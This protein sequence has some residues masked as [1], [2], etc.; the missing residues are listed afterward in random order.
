VPRELVV[1][2]QQGDADAFEALVTA[3]ADRWYATATLILHDRSRAEDAVQETM[4]R[5]WRDLPRLRDPERFDAWSRR[6]LVHACLDLAR[7]E[8][9]VRTE[10]PLETDVASSA[11]PARVTVDRDAVTAAFAELT[12]EHRAILVLRHYLGHSVP[13]V[14]DAL[15]IPLGTARSRLSRAEAAMRAV[16]EADGETVTPGGAA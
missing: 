16:L 15:G 14:A 9:H 11:D 4:I 7:S 8:R 6:I 2:A 12:A 3:S 10:L 13:E 5:A 1:R